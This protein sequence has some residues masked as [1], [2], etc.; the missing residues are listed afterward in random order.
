MS[1]KG[2]GNGKVWDVY[3]SK[4]ATN[5]HKEEK[6]MVSLAVHSSKPGD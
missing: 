5:V 2:G 4:P 3:S 1:K 6:E